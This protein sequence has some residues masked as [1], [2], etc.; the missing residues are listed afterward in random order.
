MYDLVLMT[1]I[2]IMLMIKMKMKAMVRAREGN[3]YGIRNVGKPS[4][5]FVSSYFLVS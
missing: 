4:N 2:G 1:I 5:Y 3:F